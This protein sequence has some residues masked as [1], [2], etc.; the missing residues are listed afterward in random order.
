MTVNVKVRISP[1]TAWKFLSRGHA[2]TWADPESTCDFSFMRRYPIDSLIK[3]IYIFQKTTSKYSLK[4][5]HHAKKSN[6]NG[7]C[8]ITVDLLFRLK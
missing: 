4:D 3:T 5:A 8:P 6:V 2:I 7:D 1:I